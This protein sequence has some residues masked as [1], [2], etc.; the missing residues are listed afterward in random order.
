MKILFFIS[1]GLYGAALL[2]QLAGALLK[3]E[4][5]KKAA[6]ILYLLSD[7]NYYS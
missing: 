3:G 5:L 6:W 7:V 2:L 1:L 4:S